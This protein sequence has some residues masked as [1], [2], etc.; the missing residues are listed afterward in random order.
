MRLVSL[1]LILLFALTASAQN[2][3]LDTLRAEGYEA[4]YN[5]AAEMARELS[6][7]YPR[8]NLFKLQ[9]TDALNHKL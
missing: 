4:L 9:M 1:A 5:L 6:E 3:K 7:K 8:N 2:A